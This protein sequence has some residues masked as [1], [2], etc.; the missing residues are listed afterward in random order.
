MKNKWKVGIAMAL[1]TVT[2]M[3]IL[4][5]VSAKAEDMD[6]IKFS[7]DI[8]ALTPY[9]GKT[10]SIVHAGMESVLNMSTAT[11]TELAKYYYSTPEMREF[12]K[13]GRIPNTPEEIRACYDNN[14]DFAPIGNVL[15]WA[16][17]KQ[18]DSYTVNV[19]LDKKF[20]KVV[21][22]KTVEDTSVN[23]G[24]TLYSGTDY[25]WQVIANDGNEQ[26]RSN[27]FEFSTKAGTRT[28]DLDGVSNTRD[29]G[30][31][32]TPEG[33][34]M[35]GLLYRT[36]RLDDVSEE[37]KKTAEKLGI[38]T[39]LDLRAVGEGKENPLGIA[40]VR[41]TPAPNYAYEINTPESKAAIRTIFGTFA[42]KDNYPIV[43][44]CSIGRD[45]TGTA[46]ALLNALL[47]VNENTIVN[48]YL[49]SAFAY[50]SSWHKI[51]D[52]LIGNITGLISYIKSFEGDTLSKQTENFLLDAGVTAEEIQSVKDIMLGRVQVHDNTVDCGISYENM[53]FVT[54]KPYG[55][56]KQTYAVKDGVVIDAPYTLDE[57]TIWA[58]DGVEYD[59]SQPI[60]Q[61]L[62]ITTMEKEYVDILVSVSGQEQTIKATVGETI[63]FT[64]FAK[65]GYTYKVM[66]DKGDIIT[67]LV[68]MK[69]CAVTII[70]FKS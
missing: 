21:F 51:Q 4:G 69:D 10:V 25:Y 62:T 60:T 37:G 27:I 36:A 56:A 59:F 12:N 6:I 52:G 46:T 55:Y 32:A 15:Q 29:V 41:A 67:S 66:N 31:Y 33:K 39:D 63:D 65:D 58:V 20:T 16:Y 18:A 7:N 61:D 57:D 53:Y 43:M 24:N 9:S 48:E 64:Q 45:R 13:T 34:T 42:N 47:G 30:G 19:A 68:A 22:S 1:A 40:Y 54:V 3:S 8:V 14:D 26:V 23:L 2:S 49:L 70:Y 50:I 28:I 17:D 35:Q 5:A 11:Q 38:K 44:H